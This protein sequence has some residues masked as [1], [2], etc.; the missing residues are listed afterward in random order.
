VSFGEWSK[1]I[2]ALEG[3]MEKKVQEQAI[4]NARA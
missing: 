1:V 4:Y 3:I 2:D